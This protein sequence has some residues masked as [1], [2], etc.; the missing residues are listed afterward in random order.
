MQGLGAVDGRAAEAKLNPSC[1]GGT[2]RGLRMRAE[3]G[4]SGQKGEDKGSR[5]AGTAEGVGVGGGEGCGG[6]AGEGVRG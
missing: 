1:A 5:D 4:R 3:S 2:G 6:H